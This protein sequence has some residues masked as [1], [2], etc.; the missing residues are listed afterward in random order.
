MAMALLEPLSS[1]N[2]TLCLRYKAAS[3][4]DSSRVVG[5]KILRSFKQGVSHK[6]VD[7][8]RPV[9]VQNIRK[10]GGVYLFNQEHNKD[11]VN[12]ASCWVL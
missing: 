5:R 3:E 1:S 9:C 7:S 8:G 4:K 6:A 11:K 2:P 12:S 10:H